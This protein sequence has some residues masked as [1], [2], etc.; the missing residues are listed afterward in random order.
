MRQGS[1]REL[2]G[3][4]GRLFRTGTGAGF[5]DS[6]LLERFLVC[7]DEAAEAAF[8]TLVERHGPMVLAL[9]RRV[10]NDPNDADDA[11]QATFLVLVR[12]AG[13]IRKRESIADWLHGVA[14]RVSAHAWADLSRRRTGERRA[15]A[16]T[17]TTYEAIAGNG[18][19][20]DEV[21]QLPRDLRAAV[22]LCYREGLTHEQAARR[23][24]WPVGTVRSRL[25][26]ARD[27]LRV[28]F[29]RMGL[30][31]EASLLPALAI[32]PSL[33]SDGLVASTVKAA[34]LFAARD[35]AEAGLVSASAAA[36]T[37]G[38]IRTVFISKLKITA[39]LV[40]CTGAIVS[41]A[42]LYAYQPPGPAA[43]PATA[44]PVR[45]SVGL[46]VSDAE[47]LDSYGVKIEKL[48]LAARQR[49]AHGDVDTALQNLRSIE[50]IA[51]AWKEALARRRSSTK[52]DLDASGPLPAGKRA[53]SPAATEPASADDRLSRLE[54]T[55]ERLVRSLDKRGS[56]EPVTEL[57]PVPDP[58]LVEPPPA[59]V[60]GVVR[61]VDSKNKRVE[62][63]IGSDDGLVPGHELFI[64]RLDPPA[65]SSWDIELLGMI[66]IMTTDPR[67]SVGKITGTLQGKI[68]KRGDKVSTRAPA[69][70]GRKAAEPGA[71]P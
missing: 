6:Q 54:R 15:T 68:I 23:L 18:E 37:E 47:D 41:G 55:V 70:S 4:I 40:F 60:E 19:I 44:G 61:W 29:T 62:I 39:A 33:L 59:R 26:R 21:D 46:R 48:V 3:P 32:K 8:A 58:K 67:Q 65:Q 16:M 63:T 7:H 13:A 30:A 69:E 31:P 5:S 53:G 51:G 50:L 66:R 25:A 52:A 17:S 27:R 9:C 35:A 71:R 34:M 56:A 10:L 38:V 57:N 28:R 43:E 49:Q 1:R 12:K 11:F 36:L 2:I 64:Y 20:W 45:A 22:V 42:G 24:G 14:R